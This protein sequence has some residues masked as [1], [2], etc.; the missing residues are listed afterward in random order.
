MSK[1]YRLNDLPNWNN[2]S[3]FGK[4]RGNQPTEKLAN[5]FDEDVL[6]YLNEQ[7]INHLADS[8]NL[9]NFLNE[10]SRGQF[11]DYSFFTAP[12]YKALEGFLFQIA[13]DLSL[14]SSS[15]NKLAGSYYFDETKIDKHINKL[16]KELEKAAESESKL[17]VYEKKDI[18]DR[19]KEMKGFLQH[20]RNAP[21]HFYGES[22]DTIEKA[23]RNIMIIYGAI[24]NTAKILLKAGLI[25]IKEDVH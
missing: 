2:F 8:F 6:Y 11:N 9:E 14:P 19:V 17:S 13:K 5:N 23:H 3:E 15:S 22:V 18:K 4:N 21:A 25:Q 7:V 16:L 24:D 12:A 1:H 20:Y 10:N